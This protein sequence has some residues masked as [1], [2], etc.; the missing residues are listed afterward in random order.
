MPINY[1]TSGYRRSYSKPSSG[2]KCIGINIIGI[3]LIVIGI[4]TIAIIAASPAILNRIWMSL[5]GYG[6]GSSR[7][8]LAQHVTYA[9][10]GISIAAGA[11]ILFRRVIF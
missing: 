9:L 6:I 1:S 4:I 11:I 10:G 3:A 5:T 2:G 7:L 8:L